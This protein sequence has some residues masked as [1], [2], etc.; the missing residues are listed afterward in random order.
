MALFG[1]KYDDEELGVELFFRKKKEKEKDR[2][3]LTKLILKFKASLNPHRSGELFSQ[4]SRI[5]DKYL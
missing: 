4:I 2:K 1:Q 5:L 3:K